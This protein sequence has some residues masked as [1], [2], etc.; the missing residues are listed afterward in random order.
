M[1]YFAGIICIF[2][3]ML[4][5]TSTAANE[6]KNSDSNGRNS[7]ERSQH[8]IFLETKGYTNFQRM[9]AS[10]KLKKGS[11]SIKKIYFFIT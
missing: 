10:H 3:C 1:R 6:K 11:I 9:K 8:H 2:V 5:S 7:N 4:M